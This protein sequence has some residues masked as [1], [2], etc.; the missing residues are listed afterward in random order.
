[1]VLCLSVFAEISSGNGKVLCRTQ[2]SSCDVGFCWGFF[3]CGLKQLILV[4]ITLYSSK[5]SRNSN[6]HNTPPLQGQNGQKKY[7]INLKSSSGPIHVLLINKESSSSKPT[8]FPVPPP[9][10]LAQ[11]PSQPAAPA[12]PLKPAAAPPNPPEQHDLN[13]GQELPQTTVADTPSGGSRGFPTS[14]GWGRKAAG[15]KEETVKIGGRQRKDQ[16]FA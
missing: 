15:G 12:T 8:V 16:A 13:Q 10:D 14:Y 11:P 6:F 2:V 9:D 5:F 7:Q 3:Y 1:M 4:S